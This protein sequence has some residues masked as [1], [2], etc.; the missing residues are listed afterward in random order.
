MPGRNHIEEEEEEE[1]DVVEQEEQDNEDGMPVYDPDQH[2]DERRRI[3]R[4]YRELAQDL[5][6]YQTPVYK[7]SI[8]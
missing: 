8:L 6:T 4:N 2:A 7:E 1:E 3:R 5:A